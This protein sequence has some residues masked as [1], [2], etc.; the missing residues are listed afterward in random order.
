VDYITQ[1]L[2]A[3]HVEGALLDTEFSYIFDL[4]SG[5]IY[6]YYFHQFDEVIQ[7]NLAEWL[8]SDQ[9]SRY[10]SLI[11]HGEYLP[12]LFPQETRDKAASE[13]HG[14]CNQFIVFIL[15]FFSVIGFLIF[16]IYKKRSK[17]STNEP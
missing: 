17:K 11:S 12:N 4:A 10:D 16:F 6:I 13:F 7:I 5:D 15:I 2:D 1:I 3:F 9:L 8:S 14:Y